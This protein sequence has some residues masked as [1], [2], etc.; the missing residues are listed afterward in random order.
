VPAKDAISIAAK[1]CIIIGV[2]ST[3]KS[4]VG[5]YP[6]A[7]AEV[8]KVFFETRQLKIIYLTRFSFCTNLIHPFLHF[9]WRLKA[10]YQLLMC[11]CFGGAG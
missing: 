8:K 7:K 10:K 2:E 3:I 4:S 1:E 9:L 11:D 5:V 6:G